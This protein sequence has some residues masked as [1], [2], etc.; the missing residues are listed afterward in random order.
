[1]SLVSIYNVL[2]VVA[3][4]YLMIAFVGRETTAEPDVEPA[5]SQDSRLAYLLS[6]LRNP[7]G[8]SLLAPPSIYK[9]K[10]KPSHQSTPTKRD[11]GFWIWMPAQGYVPVPRQ[12]A[13]GE[14]GRGSGSSNLLRYG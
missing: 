14:S 8:V 6:N 11:G 5:A 2:T 10:F 9:S 7:N 13:G 4:S 3:I 1:M 12:D